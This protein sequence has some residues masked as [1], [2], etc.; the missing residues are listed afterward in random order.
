MTEK[1][2]FLQNA[3]IQSES[4]SDNGDEVTI[5]DIDTHLAKSSSIETLPIVK[6]NYV[7]FSVPTIPKIGLLD[8]GSPIPTEFL[9][10]SFTSD[11][12]ANS[13]G[14]NG[15]ITSNSNEEQQLNFQ[16]EVNS[17][18]N[19]NQE[20]NKIIH[21][22]VQE[23]DTID[24]IAAKFG[25]TSDYLRKRNNME[26]GTSIKVGDIL[27]VNKLTENESPPV[28]KCSKLSIDFVDPPIP[29]KLYIDGNYLMF[30][31]LP[32]NPEKGSE[33][34]KLNGKGNEKEND[35]NDADNEMK[36]NLIGHLESVTLPHPKV[37]A[38]ESPD[39]SLPD[40]PMI[41][42][43]TYLEDP[44]DDMTMS[45]IYFE[46]TL[47]EVNK[48]KK[49]VETTA[50][51]A[52]QQINYTAPNPSEIPFKAEDEEE[53]NNSIY[54]EQKSQN[55]ITKQQKSKNKF[56]T[57]K[58]KKVKNHKTHINDFNNEKEK[59]DKEAFPSTRLSKPFTSLR[60]FIRLPKFKS[61]PP[62]PLEETVRQR[63]RTLSEL[64]K[65]LQ[66]QGC[67]EILS[68]R[69]IDDLRAH[70]PYRFKNLDWNL[71]YQ[72]SRD[73][74]SYTSF[75][76][77]TEKAMPVVLLIKTDKNEIIG[78]FIS[79]G[80]KFSKR[81]YGNGDI[82]VFRFGVNPKCEVFKWNEGT[83][84]FFV[85]SS[86][87]DISVGGGGASAI[88]IDGNLLNAI[89]EPCPTF[90]S[91]QLTSETQFQCNEIEVWRIGNPNNNNSQSYYV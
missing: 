67:S 38:E 32:E 24:S 8:S 83:N 54:S 1:V 21:Y 6:G 3:E 35:S 5:D 62:P 87:T 22:E 75:F 14:E 69:E 70:F 10:N 66:H 49:L 7:S 58:S 79:C 74:A 59:D 52:Q 91:P 50:I 43:I 34:E 65:I 60:N 71:L 55:H 61:N 57:S 29:G 77:N 51:R 9:D 48:I 80:L 72:L 39:L 81:Y 44:L 63:R 15:Q 26:P 12:T 41:Y 64:P 47:S 82:F 31:T 2:S 17:N 36:I 46:T 86:K 13:N 33:K 25:L 30:R 40:T 20:K 4:I 18:L 45:A 11:L 89:S 23:D 28:F 78:A 76:N 73:G 27:L 42:M 68:D 88:W 37:M 85:S 56:K 16:N 84:Q 53:P 90:H 19:N